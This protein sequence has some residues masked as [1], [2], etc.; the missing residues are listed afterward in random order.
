LKPKVVAGV[1]LGIVIFSLVIGFA[2]IGSK[3]T[4]RGIA[5]ENRA[6]G[7]VGV[8]SITGPI[9]SGRSVSSFWGAQTGSED[10]LNQ[11]RKAAAD[12]NIRAVVLRLNSPGGTAAGA[13]EIAS[14]VDKLRRTAGKKVVVSMGDTSTSGAY[15]IASRAEKIV[16]NPGT[17]TGSI[18]VIMQTEDLQKFYNKI[19][20][21]TNTFK[22]GPHKDMGS[23]NRPVTPEEQTIFQSM[24]DDI[25]D[26]FLTAVAEGRNMDRQAVRPLADGRVFT[27]R[28]AKEVGLIDE[29]GGYHEAIALAG[30]LAGLG[31]EPE[32]VELGPG[33]FW[34][35][36][37]SGTM[38]GL[39][40][41][42]GLQ[43]TLFQPQE[44]NSI[45]ECLP[46][47]ALWLLYPADY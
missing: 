17:L 34:R 12:T 37:L 30:D 40:P 25:Y 22:S 46:Y 44:I 3:K 43:M 36:L 5:G 6:G 10:I 9:I 4:G 35:S 29:L 7:V 42:N 11:L 20:I 2:V 24:I 27:G 19:G 16:A 38:N 45:K 23:P 26:Q 33:Q 41:G 13:Q 14:E 15:W 47:P 32:V 39:A 31:T 1:L 21:S 28:Q 18:G 8:I